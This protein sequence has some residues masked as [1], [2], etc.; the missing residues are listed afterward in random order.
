MIFAIGSLARLSPVQ[1]QVRREYLKAQQYTLLPKFDWNFIRTNKYRGAECYQVDDSFLIIEPILVWGGGGGFFADK[2]AKVTLLDTKR[3]ETVL[4][5]AIDNWQNLRP[6]QL[7]DGKLE[8][9]T[10]LIVALE[11]QDSG[12]KIKREIL[13]PPDSSM[14]SGIPYV[15]YYLKDSLAI[16]VD[17]G[18]ICFVSIARPGESYKSLR[19]KC[20]Q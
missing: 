6:P 20:F 19:N 4:Y 12:T 13:G 10:E 1:M 9:R 11:E 17:W 7:D 5:R 8:E 3:H 16:G 18:E 2:T 15:V 14:G